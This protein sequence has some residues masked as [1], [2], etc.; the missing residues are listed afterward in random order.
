MGFIGSLEPARDDV[1]SSILLQQLGSVGRRYKRESRSA[2][3]KIV[4]EIYSPPR[5][6]REIGHSRG[7]HLMAGFALDLTVVD[8]DDGL[9][10]DF[11][12]LAKQAKARK[13]LREQKPY[14]PIGS[15]MC[16]Q[17]STWQALNNSKNLNKE[18]IERAYAEAVAAGALLLNESLSRSQR[19]LVYQELTIAYAALD[20]AD[21]AAQSCGAWLQAD[22]ETD[23]DP[24]WW[25]PK[26][27]EACGAA[28][29]GS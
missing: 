12:S 28:S 25:S 24:K 8:P 16:R 5:I 14:F 17:F 21:L 18:E 3:K 9:P 6:T 19:A 29:D 22:P 2:Y 11:T 1:V 10:W 20:D 26:I 13:M 27:L 15:P 7:S 4:S 23:L